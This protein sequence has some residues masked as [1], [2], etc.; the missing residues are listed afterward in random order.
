MSKKTLKVGDY[1]LG[2]YGPGTIQRIELCEKPGDKYG[3]SVKEVYFDL[4]DRCVVDLE[5]NRFEY[6]ADLD[7]LTF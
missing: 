4:V 2:K 6:G 5:N 3:L 1:V 7:F